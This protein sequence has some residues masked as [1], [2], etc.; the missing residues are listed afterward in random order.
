MSLLLARKRPGMNLSIPLK[1][2]YEA[3]SVTSVQHEKSC[4]IVK[5]T[6][7][8]ILLNSVRNTPNLCIFY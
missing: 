8:G 5:Y 1:K 2:L 4:F 6:I 3:H 7:L